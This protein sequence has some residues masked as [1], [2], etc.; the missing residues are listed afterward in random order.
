MK[1]ILLGLM[2]FFSA[3][4][5]FAATDSDSVFN[6][7]L[8]SPVPTQTTN[9]GTTS[10]DSFTSTSYNEYQYG[11]CPAG[12]TYNGSSQFPNQVRTVNQLY[13]NGI[14]TGTTYSAWYDLDSDC[15]TTEY[16]QIACPTNYTGQYYQ[17]RQVTTSDTGYQYS[18]WTTYA[19]TCVYNPPPPPVTTATQQAAC[20]STNYS[21]NGTIS[22]TQSYSQ[23]VNQIS[24]D[25]TDFATYYYCWG[26]T[27]KTTGSQPPNN[28]TLYDTYS[29]ESG[30]GTGPYGERQATGGAACWLQQG[31]NNVVYQATYSTIRN[32]GTCH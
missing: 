15:Q 20:G 2:L 26:G 22:A 17:S 7:N 1:Q 19:N 21:P 32:P 30:V 28:G 11:A 31:T 8:S 10:G 23:V 9:G 13:T 24:T 12:F 14:Y 16:Q 4:I 25:L 3:T 27:V 18:D 5:S 6:P 29:Y